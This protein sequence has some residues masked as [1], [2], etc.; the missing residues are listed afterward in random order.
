[1]FSSAKELSEKL[2]TARYIIDPVTLSVV[3]LAARMKKPLLIEG[4]PGCGKKELAYAKSLMDYLFRWLELRFLKGEQGILFELSNGKQRQTEVGNAAK[5][6]SEIVN[7]GDAPTCQFCG[8]LM[9]RNGSCYRCM[10]CGSTS[11]CS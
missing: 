3:Y 4:P 7:L 9:V 11:G 8:S 2:R 10:E 1:V 5:A 6:L